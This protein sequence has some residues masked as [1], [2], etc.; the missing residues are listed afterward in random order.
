MHGLN[1]MES[2]FSYSTKVALSFNMPINASER[3]NIYECLSVSTSLEYISNSNQQIFFQPFGWPR[4][5]SCV[6]QSNPFYIED[7]AK[8]KNGTGF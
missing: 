4:D 8:V 7:I 1:Q 6:K 3:C 5:W 2:R